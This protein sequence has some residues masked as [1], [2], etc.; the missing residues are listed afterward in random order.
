MTLD[1]KVKTI[2]GMNLVDF[3]RNTLKI[4]VP[5]AI[6]DRDKELLVLIQ[7]ALKVESLTELV[8]KLLARIFHRVIRSPDRVLHFSISKLM[9][10]FQ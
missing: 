3:L 9:I 5:Q 1:Q 6:M 2:W 8:V 4:T 7:Q 10:R